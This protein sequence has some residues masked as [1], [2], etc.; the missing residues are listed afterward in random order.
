[1]SVHPS[2]LRSVHPSVRPVLFLNDGN[3]EFWGWKDF[4]WLTTITTTTSMMIIMINECRQKGR[5]WCTPAVLV[6]QIPLLFF[7]FFQILFGPIQKIVYFQISG[8]NN[9]CS[10]LLHLSFSFLFRITDL[11][12]IQNFCLLINRTWRTRPRLTDV[13]F[14]YFFFRNAIKEKDPSRSVGD[15]AKVSH[16]WR[17]KSMFNNWRTFE[18][19]KILIS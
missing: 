15:I 16:F 6:F 7:L 9:Y 3:R 10:F 11:E 19:D 1:M 2:V 12:I 14:K 4:K 17:H 5:I 8:E 18:Y 13:V